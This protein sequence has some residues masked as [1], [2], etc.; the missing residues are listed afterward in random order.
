MDGPQWETED[1]RGS[2][3]INKTD[4]FNHINF[5]YV[6]FHEYWLAN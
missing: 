1:L 2:K 5:Q 6:H 3:P 4:I